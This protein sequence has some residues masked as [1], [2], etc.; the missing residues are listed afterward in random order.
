LL[1][2]HLASWRPLR[3]SSGDCGA[4]AGGTGSAGLRRTPSHSCYAGRAAPCVGLATKRE[5]R[6]LL[7][8]C[9]CRNSEP[10]FDSHRDF[11]PRRRHRHTLA[12]VSKLPTSAINQGP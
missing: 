10:V 4:P 6:T 7:E 2:T 12:G 8:N 11:C 9:T 3:S 1:I 5:Q